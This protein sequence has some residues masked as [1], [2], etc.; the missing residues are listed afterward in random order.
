[1]VVVHS[2]TSLLSSN[3]TKTELKR[4]AWSVA[5]SVSH[6]SVTLSLFQSQTH[7]T[8][9]FHFL[10]TSSRHTVW[11]T[12]SCGLSR[13][14]FVS[15]SDVT[16]SSISRHLADAVAR[17]HVILRLLQQCRLAKCVVELSHTVYARSEV[18]SL[19]LLFQRRPAWADRSETKLQALVYG[20]L[21]ST[22]AVFR[23]AI[24]SR[25]LMSSF[26]LVFT[27]TVVSLS[28]QLQLKQLK[29]YR[30]KRLFKLCCHV[31]YA[32]S[33]KTKMV[34]VNR[35]DFFILF[36]R[37]R[38]GRYWDCFHSKLLIPAKPAFRRREGADT[39]LR[40]YKECPFSRVSGVTKST[41]NLEEVAGK[42]CSECGAKHLSVQPEIL[43]QV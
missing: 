43:Q 36:L 18:F 28:S 19:S 39:E 2:W 1:M 3:Y 27:E 30:V 5:L 7:L 26:L 24:G 34:S 10:I 42:R 17:S 8:R 25:K 35:D 38:L 29:L 14:Y 40:G 12:D 4:I 15:Q 13:I 32:S 41:G 16:A 31:A 11:R 9:H 22:T 37:V 23:Y 21:P 33:N 6:I 20:I